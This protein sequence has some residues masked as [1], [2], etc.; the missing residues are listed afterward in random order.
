[1]V[2]ELCAILK[3]RVADLPFLE[4][5]AGLVQPVMDVRYAGTNQDIKIVK[6]MPVS[7]DFVDGKDEILGMERQLVPDQGRKGMLYFE[8]FG[9]VPDTGRDVPANK[10]ALIT[11]VR[12]VCWMNKNAMVNYAYNEITAVTA[13][14]VINKLC[15]GN[16]TSSNGI[17]RLMVSLS[18]MPI[19]DINIFS[20]YNY[21]EAELQFL[22]PPFEYFA[23]DLNCKYRIEPRCLPYINLNAGT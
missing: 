4:T 9:T 14:A 6:K 19:Q 2:K 21:H 17:V 8:D 1:M 20:R 18:A 3:G 13:A 10:I 7:Y 15:T 12:V 5:I 22:R 16:A 23:L 11:K